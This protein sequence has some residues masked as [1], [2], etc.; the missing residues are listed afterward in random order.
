MAQI[1]R[2][3]LGGISGT[4]GTVVGASWKGIDYIRAKS[5]PRSK[6]SFTPAQLE[7][8]ARFSAAIRF[9]GSLNGLPQ[10]TFRQYAVKQTGA[11]SALAYLL[12]NAITGSSPLF[13]IDYSM[14]L[15]SRG[16]L[17]GAVGAA[18]ASTVAGKVAFSW[19]NN[20]GSGKA[21]ASD[22]ALLVVH[23]PETMQTVYTIG[24]ANR[25]NAAG[26]LSVAG[27]SG[28]EVET[29]MAFLSADGR[30]V[31]TSVYT[32]QVTIL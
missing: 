29:W 19:T 2:G 30:E 12:K 26:E 25:G 21:L 8:Q 15:I 3:I 22:S 11:N 20:S 10:I 28:K 27:F 14:A 4:V 24:P 16:D 6:G 1:S 31:A 13:S 9:I 5:L 32:G 7:Q 18:A 23:C 17:P